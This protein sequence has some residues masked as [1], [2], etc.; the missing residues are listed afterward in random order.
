MLERIYNYPKELI[1]ADKQDIYEYTSRSNEPV[2]KILEELYG[3]A[4]V[5]GLK[6][7]DPVAIF[8]VVYRN[9]IIIVNTHNCQLSSPLRY[10][11]KRIQNRQG[12]KFWYVIM[13]MMKVLVCT[14]EEVDN[15]F[16]RLSFD[17]EMNR[18]RHTPYSKIADAI[19]P[20]AEEYISSNPKHSTDLRLNPLPPISVRSGFQIPNV[21]QWVSGDTEEAT[22]NDLLYILGSYRKKRDRTVFFDIMSNSKACNKADMQD[23][24]RKL[25]DGTFDSW[26]C[27]M[28]EMKQSPKAKC[29]MENHYVTY[30][31]KLVECSKENDKLHTENDSCHR[32]I[33]D[34]RKQIE[35]DLNLAARYHRE[36]EGACIEVEKHNME[37][38]QYKAQLERALDAKAEATDCI[39]ISYIIKQFQKM[40]A[41]SSH[42]K[43]CNIFDEMN[44]LLGGNKVWESHKDEI[45]DI[46]AQHKDSANAMSVGYNNGFIA[47]NMN[48]K[49]SPETEA[50]LLE[51]TRN[52]H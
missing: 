26:W 28:F 33:E 6:C 44:T 25:A 31:K 43:V 48:L 40:L 12:R 30:L 2:N 23:V 1:Y 10:I 15:E 32:Q 47:E 5:A 17:N 37:I 36:Y 13:T 27:D 24:D 3:T 22:W 20:L 19:R 38:E 50:K 7:D 52:K 21:D 14:K 45:V 49:I 35:S 51:N 42:D 4:V 39:P 9:A 11:S 29:Q 8:N 41:Y 16:W 46:L 18:L 34:Y